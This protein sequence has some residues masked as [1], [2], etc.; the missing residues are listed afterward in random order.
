MLLKANTD[1]LPTISGIYFFYVGK[2]YFIM[3]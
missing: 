3:N 1:I 2:E